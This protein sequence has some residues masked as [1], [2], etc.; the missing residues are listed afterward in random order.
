MSLSNSRKRMTP[1]MASEGLN[2]LEGAE[3][4]SHA[5]TTHPL[6]RLV[7]RHGSVITPLNRTGDGPAFFCVHPISGDVTSFSDFAGSLGPDCRFYGIQVPVQK[8]QASFAQSVAAVA[9]HHVE[10]LTAFQPSG[11]IVLGGWSVGAIIA[12]EMAQQLQI[13]GREIPLLI[14]LDGAPSNTGAGIG[15]WNPLYGWRLICNLPGW[16]KYEV[17]QTGSM[18]AFTQQAFKKLV[19]RAQMTL[20]SVRNEQT[21]S[22]SAV[23]DLLDR[24]GWKSNQTAFIR[25]LYSAVRAYVPKPYAGRVVVYESKTQPIDHLLQVGAA[26]RKIA[27]NV[28]IVRLDGN[29]VSTLRNPAV[30]VLTAHLRPLLAELQR[31]SASSTTADTA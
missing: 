26:W 18:R 16:L 17:Q 28:E 23:Q 7:S 10:A 4:D 19:F 21:L 31:A 2:P 6:W 30:A 14:A 12:L 20:P 5:R 9:R 8:M 3:R 13:L 15:R 25:A 1:A 22:G 27:A 24:P 29:H 11:A